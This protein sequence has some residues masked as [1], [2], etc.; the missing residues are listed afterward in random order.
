MVS[1]NIHARDVSGAQWARFDA[2][3]KPAIIGEFQFGSADRGLFRPG[4]Y[5]VAAED[6]RGPAYACYLRSALADPDIV[7]C[8]WFQYVDEPLTGRPLDGENGHIGF[9]SVADVPYRDFV[10]AVRTANLALL[11]ALQ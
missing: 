10:A 9:V 3:G 4:L 5:T 7:G 8:H 2:L 6:R 11:G 1:F